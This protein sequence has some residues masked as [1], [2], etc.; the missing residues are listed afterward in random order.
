MSKRRQHKAPQQ[1]LPMKTVEVRLVS[2]E[3]VHAPGVFAWARNGYAFPG[4]RRSMINVISQTYKLKPAIAKK[5]LSG[6]LPYE[7]VDDAVVFQA[8]EGNY[9]A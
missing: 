2:S 3:M 7:I 5:L 4:D 8:P 1:E 9:R 6:S